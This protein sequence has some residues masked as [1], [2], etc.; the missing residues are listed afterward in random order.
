M[1]QRCA[2]EGGLIEGGVDKRPIVLLQRLGKAGHIQG[3]ESG[4][5]VVAIGPVVEPIVALGDGFQRRMAGFQGRESIQRIIQQSEPRTIQVL[6]QK[7]GYPIELRRHEAGAAVEREDGEP[8]HVRSVIDYV[9]GLGIGIERHVRHIAAVE[10]GGQRI[11]RCVVQDP[12]LVRLA[13]L[14]AA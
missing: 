2:V 3:A 11:G 9:P 13:G 6:N 8:G 12:I 7:R 14:D 10:V 4:R 1:H 5:G